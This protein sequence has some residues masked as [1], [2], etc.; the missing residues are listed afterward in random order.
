MNRRSFLGSGLGA[1]VASVAFRAA[2]KDDEV[3][4]PV[5]PCPCCCSD[6]GVNF[7]SCDESG[8]FLEGD[9]A[10]CAPDEESQ[11]PSEEEADW[12]VVSTLP[13]TG[14]GPGQGARVFATVYNAIP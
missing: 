8:N 12:P 3:D 4:I 9:P 2:A 13:T 7:Y 11:V 6:D 10:N 1:L 14:A 5:E